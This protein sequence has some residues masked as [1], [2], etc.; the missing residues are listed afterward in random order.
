[1]LQNGVSNHGR[2]SIKAF[3]VHGLLRATEVLPE[4]REALLHDRQ[5]LPDLCGLRRALGAL[6]EGCSELEWQ[7]P[8]RIFDVGQEQ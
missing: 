3:E 2:C 8:R 1:M 6:H 5:K 7:E 4:V